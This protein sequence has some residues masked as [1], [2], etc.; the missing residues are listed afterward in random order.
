[1]GDL[2]SWKAV[3]SCKNLGKQSLVATKKSVS[4]HCFISE[5]KGLSQLEI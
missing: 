4:Q 1:M 3:L 2:L 5:E